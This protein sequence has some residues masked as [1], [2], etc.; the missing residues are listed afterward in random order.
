MTKTEQK[1]DNS[2]RRRWFW[3]LPTAILCPAAAMMLLCNYTP[4]A[5]RPS[6]PQNSDQVSPYLT[7]TLGP[8]FFNNIQLDKPFELRV[9]QPGLNEILCTQFANS[10]FDG[11][12][13]TNP[14]IVFDTD[15]I[16]LMGTLNYMQ[17]G[18]VVTIIAKPQMTDTGQINLNI[19]SIRMGVLPVTKLVTFLAQQ[20]FEQSQDC[21][22]GE[23][24]IRLMTEAI[25]QNKPF[26]PVF[27]LSD[28]TARIT[29]FAVQPALLTLRFQPQP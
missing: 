25:I 20:A 17:I 7:H 29:E 14:V 13:F 8:D 27:E 11:F 21:F 9:E 26:D 24:D 19:Q 4:L 5:Y 3:I 18:S 1:C 12:S 6:A 22:E 28:H 2:R 10:R 15:T 23:E 16:Y